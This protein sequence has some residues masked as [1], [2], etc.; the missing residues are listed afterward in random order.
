MPNSSWQRWRYT[1][2][3]VFNVLASIM[4]ITNLIVTFAFHTK[5]MGRP[6]DPSIGFVAATV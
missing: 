5:V 1:L 6:L 2:G 3:T 4:P